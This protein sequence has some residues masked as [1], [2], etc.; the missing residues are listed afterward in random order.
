MVMQQIA[1]FQINFFYLDTYYILIYNKKKCAYSQ[2]PV[3]TI[4]EFK[5]SI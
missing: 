5:T 1:P 4:A 2:E 3:Y